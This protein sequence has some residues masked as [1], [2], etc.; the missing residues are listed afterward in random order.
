M[1][2]VQ[3]IPGNPINGRQRC[4]MCWLKV[5]TGVFDVVALT[6]K[7]KLHVTSYIL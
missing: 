6:L 1:I 5:L 2:I 3:R 4:A 7:S